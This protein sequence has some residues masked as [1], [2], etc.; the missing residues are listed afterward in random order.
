MAKDI[1]HQTVRRAL[2]KEGW[3]IT[4][5]PFRIPKRVIGAKLEID[6]GLEKII[7]AEKDT[8]KIVVEVKS[9]LK[10][11]LIHEFHSVLGQYLNYTI[12]LEK[13][14]SERQLYLAIPKN[15]YEDLSEM[16][17]FQASIEKFDVKIIVFEPTTEV[18]SSWKK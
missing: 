18:I 12:G 1:Y 6:L 8:E 17:L 15:T 10:T 5:D 14:N 9:F 2:E 11:S 16:S 4:H 3:T 7:V 13:I